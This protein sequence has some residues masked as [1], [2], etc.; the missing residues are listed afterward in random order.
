MQK[1][2]ILNAKG[3]AL[4]TSALLHTCYTGLVLPFRLAKILDNSGVF[5]VLL[6]AFDKLLLEVLVHLHFYIHEEDIVKHNVV[7]TNY[8]HVLRVLRFIL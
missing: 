4:L 7:G 6:V 3:F 8:Y 1:S 5:Y 2:A